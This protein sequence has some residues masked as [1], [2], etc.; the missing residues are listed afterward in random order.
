MHADRG[1]GESDGIVSA[2]ADENGCRALRVPGL[3]CW[4]Y[5]SLDVGLLVG[6][7]AAR[8]DVLRCDP[9]LSRCGFYTA[10]VAGEE[11]SGYAPLLKIGDGF[12]GVGDGVSLLDRRP[13]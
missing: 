5:E 2:V 6:W 8:G 11:M 7:G 4:H 13:R 3:L 12:H 9:E 1:G 10:F